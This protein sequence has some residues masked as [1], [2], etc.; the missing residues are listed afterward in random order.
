MGARPH[1]G[2]ERTF[3]PRSIGADSFPTRN[4]HVDLGARIALNDDGKAFTILSRA[5]LVFGVGALF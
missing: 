1:R 2:C 5:M 4:L 3:S